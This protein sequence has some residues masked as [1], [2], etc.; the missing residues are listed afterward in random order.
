MKSNAI[1]VICCL[2]LTSCATVKVYKD[3]ELKVETG[4]PMYITKPYLLIE[5]NGA[6]DVAL[7]TTILYL[8]DMA[9]PRYIKYKPGLGSAKLSMAFSN[10]VLTSY[11]MESDSKVPELISAIGKIP[12]D[13]MT[14]ASGIITS[15]ATAYTATHPVAQAAT[16]N[17][18][19]DKETLQKAEKLVTNIIEEWTTTYA[20]PDGDPGKAVIAKELKGKL[21]S[22][23][24]EL[25]RLQTV[26][27]TEDDSKN[28]QK[29]I[30]DII[31]ET[32]KLSYDAGKGK[33]YKDFNGKLDK[34]TEVLTN[35]LLEIKKPGPVTVI[36]TPTPPQ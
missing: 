21:L 23:L 18:A 20:L 29:D 34:I 8:P 5:Y 31:A 28:L 27:P 32:G 15:N 6:K 10:S 25:Q 1:I 4:V 7:K 36:S 33:A 2:L 19:A 17:Q 12:S 13:L 26:T 9:D 24:E 16:E 22:H 14:A 35:E 3:S 11:G 30:T